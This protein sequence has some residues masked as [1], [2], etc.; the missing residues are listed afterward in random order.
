M[1]ISGYHLLR[2]DYCFGSYMFTCVCMASTHSN[3][4]SLLMLLCLKMDLLVMYV[5]FTYTV[6]VVCKGE[7]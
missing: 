6:V 5:V 3:E 4:T 7:T 2:Y 1:A